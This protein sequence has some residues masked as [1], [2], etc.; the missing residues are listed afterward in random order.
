MTADSS[1]VPGPDH[2]HR[3]DTLSS[4]GPIE[5]DPASEAA[6]DA[7]IEAGWSLD[8]VAPE[9]RPAASRAMVIM[10]LLQQTAPGFQE[11]ASQSLVLR[12]LARVAS[13]T[14]AMNARD[15]AHNAAAALSPE[16]VHAA[17]AWVQAGFDT[18]RLHEPARTRARSH[19]YIADLLR[20]GVAVGHRKGDLAGR[21]LR[22]IDLV[23]SNESQNLEPIPFSSIS[24]IRRR[25]WDVVAAAAMVLVAASIMWP[26]LAAV[27]QRGMELQCGSNMQAVASAM[28]AYANQNQ[29]SLPMAVASF[30][31]ERWW[32]VDEK[33]PV[34]NSSNL[35]TLVKSGYTKAESLA[36]PGNPKACFTSSTTNA[37]DWRSLDEISYSYQLMC[38]R[39]AKQWNHNARRV[40]LA[41][42][43]PAVLRAVRG[44]PLDPRENSPN[45]RGTGQHALYTDGSSEWMPE[46]HMKTDGGVEPD[47][48]WL[49]RMPVFRVEGR[50]VK[51]EDGNLILTLTGRELPAD[52]SD[53]FLGP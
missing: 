44:E 48:I 15:E 23:E 6:L 49:P 39:T 20:G 16:D 35:Y 42:R 50:V 18:S 9:L 40:I 27:R 43:S 13:S 4:Q 28:S 41:D 19:E 51:S 21:T 26:V 36:C 1:G 33:R 32:D 10:G 11:A 22:L 31:P 53:V 45:H 34:A 29:D 17:D 12:T 47:C 3:S 5:L 38:N 37:S 8:K 24:W 14:P 30:G 25:A 46:S 2:A 7:L 52:G